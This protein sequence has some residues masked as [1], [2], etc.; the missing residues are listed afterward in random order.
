[1]T[2][3]WYARFLITTSIQPLPK[4]TIPY[5]ITTHS[6]PANYLSEIIVE[7]DA[8]YKILSNLNCHKSPGCDSID[9]VIL[10]NCAISL[11]EPVSYL[12]NQSLQSQQ[13]PD[14]WKVHKICPIPKKGDLLLVQNYRPISLLCI[15]SK[16]MERAILDVITPFVYP[17]ISRNQYG[18]MPNRSC[19][20]ELLVSHTCIFESIENHKSVDAIYLD[21]EKAFDSI[22]HP[23][24]LLK[25][26][27]LGITRPL[28]KCYLLN[29]R[30]FVCIDGLLGPLL[31][32][33]Y[34]N[35]L[36]FAV[37]NSPCFLFADD[38]KIFNSVSTYSSS[39]LIQADL[40]SIEA[41]CKEWKLNLSSK[42]CTVMRLSLNPH[43]FIPEYL[44]YNLKL[45]VSKQH[46]DLGIIINNNLSWSS[47]YDYI[48][49]Q[50]YKS[51]NLVRR[52][53]SLSSS[54]SL[55]KQLYL[56]LVRSKITYCSQLWR[57]HLLKDI[58]RLE[59][60]QRRVTKFILNDYTSTYRSRL[61]SLN[62]LPLMYYYE[63]QDIIFLVKCIK[64]PPDNLDVFQY[65]SF[66]SKIRPG[67]LKFNY[68]R[69][70]KTRFFYFNRIVKLWN[71]LPPLDLSN[72]LA[73]IQ[74]NLTEH[75]HH[76]FLKNFSPDNICSFHYSCPCCKCV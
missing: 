46:R 20:T 76:H 39:N 4:A 9:S 54:I 65:I 37:K 22:P 64:D 59:A 31:F 8:V 45:E 50:A 66:S 30:H 51:L 3:R 55:K 13:F 7:P 10:K 38:S 69:S 14:E 44:L 57:P 2:R 52:T 35:D 26:W 71:L 40:Y 63:I 23:E 36:P 5:L 33:V 27:L 29:R 60:I 18:F 6:V 53:M 47:H 32:L 68:R 24:L 75:F 19:L 72:S 70:T 16:V 28:W 15:L 17:K 74:R 67:N 58:R 61:C 25:L 21:F 49:L 73:T 41:W 62:L 48:C 11:Y 56:A 12:F 43:T 42:K 1:M 34:I